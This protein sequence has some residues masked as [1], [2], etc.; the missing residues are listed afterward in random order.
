MWSM[1]P[2]K[3]YT[4]EEA[5][6]KDQKN[7]GQ[8]PKKNFW[9]VVNDFF[10]DQTQSVR[11]NAFTQAAALERRIEDGLKDMPEGTLKAEWQKHLQDLTELRTSLK[12]GETDEVAK[13]SIKAAKIYKKISKLEKICPF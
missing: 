7:N 1:K 2:Q 12:V 10:S 13:Q 8:E 11:R 6:R 5:R 9:E 3:I 4:S